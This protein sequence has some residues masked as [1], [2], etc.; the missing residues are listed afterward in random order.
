MDLVGPPVRRTHGCARSVSLVQKRIFISRV[1]RLTLIVDGT[2]RHMER[3]PQSDKPRWTPKILL[4]Y[5][6]LQLPSQALVFLALVV[7]RRWLD[8][9]AWFFWTCISCW[10]LKD[11]VLF[12]LVWR[13]YDWDC[14]ANAHSMVG[15]RGT[16]VEFIAPAGYVRVRGELWRAEAVGDRLPIRAGEPVT[17]RGSRGLT[18]LV[19]AER[20]E[21]LDAGRPH[22][23]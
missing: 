12:P 15:L 21:G 16:A 20:G 18:L 1:V 13:A 4:R 7:V 14:A 2:G 5:A 23:S 9:P 3:E 22:S 10:V 19:T 17:V 6:L 11:V 8:L